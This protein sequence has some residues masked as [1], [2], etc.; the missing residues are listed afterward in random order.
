[1]ERPWAGYGI[2]EAIMKSKDCVSVSGILSLGV[3]TLINFG[4]GSGT[5]SLTTHNTLTLRGAFSSVHVYFFQRIQP[6]KSSFPTTSPAE[7][8]SC[9]CKL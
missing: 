8:F 2:E 9:V 6:C 4:C 7:S 3:L 5:N 1:M